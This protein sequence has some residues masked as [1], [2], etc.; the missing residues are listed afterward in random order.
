MPIKTISLAGI[1]LPMASDSRLTLDPFTQASLKQKGLSDSNIGD[2]ER[3]P[4]DL[5]TQLLT[6]A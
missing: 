3:R 4:N 6:F 5:N 2:L 1:A